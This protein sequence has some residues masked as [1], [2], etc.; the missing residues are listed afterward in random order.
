V[1]L[2]HGLHDQAAARAHL[3][4]IMALFAE[5]V[6]CR[7]GVSHA[8]GVSVGVAHSTTDDTADGLFRRADSA[9]YDAKR[10]TEVTSAYRT[11]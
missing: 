5:P 11:A 10:S 4:R 3:E 7:G 1:L 9:M 6:R 2:T 8:V